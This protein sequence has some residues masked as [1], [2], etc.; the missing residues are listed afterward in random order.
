[1]ALSY[2]LIGCSGSGKSTTLHRILNLYPQVIYH[3]KYNFMQLVYLKIDCPHDG[4]LKN[5]CLHFFKAID[6]ALGTDFERKVA[7]KR[8]GIEALLNY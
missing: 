1:T 2:S 6:V 3:E 4:S 8:L 5:L 7:L